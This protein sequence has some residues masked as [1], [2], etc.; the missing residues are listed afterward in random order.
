MR[1]IVLDTETTGLSGGTGTYAFM[2]GIG[3]FDDG[4]FVVEQFLMRDQAEEAA[5]LA[6][7]GERLARSRFM[8][9]FN[10]KSFDVP[11][12]ETRY[13]LSRLDADLLSAPTST[14]SIPPGGSGSEAFRAAA[15]GIWRPS[16]S[17]WSV[18]AMF[19]VS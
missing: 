7:L 19:P 15:S 13:I 10:G 4:K 1:Q 18:S 5:M 6:L 16:F 8:V 11:L 3:Y 12:L 2:V 14:F 17:A 9:S